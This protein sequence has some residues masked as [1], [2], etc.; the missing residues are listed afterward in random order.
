[1]KQDNKNIL[2]RLR[3]AQEF[4]M[5]KDYQRALENYHSIE[6]DLKDSP[7]NQPAIWIEIGWNY[8]LLK[9]FEHAAAYFEMALESPHMNQKQVFDCLRLTGFCYEF[10]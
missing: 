2:D 1:M 6:A 9:Q 10:M 8:Y 5:Q 3:L 7:E 4:F